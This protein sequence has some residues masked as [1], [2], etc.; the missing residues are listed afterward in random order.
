MESKKKTK[1]TQIFR[2]AYPH[3][4]GIE[5]VMNQINDCLPDADFEK[6]VL[7]CSN[8][9][10]SSVENGVKYNRCK[11]LFEFASNNISPKFIWELSK[12]KTDIIHYHMPF[13]FA[14]IA[15]FIARPKYKKLYIT[16]HSSFKGYEKIMKPFWGL[17]RKFYDSADKIHIL[18]HNIIEYDC[19]LE[20][21]KNKCTVIPYGINT[22]QY[23]NSENVE[24]IRANYSSKKILLCLGRLM[25]IK[26]F[27]YV[28]ESMKNIKNAVLLIAGNGDELENLQKIVKQNN[29][30]QK[31]FFVGELVDEQI[32]A[33]YYNAC[34]IFV[35]P[36]I[37][38]MFGIV[39]LEAMR[40]GK[41]VINTNLGTGANY[42]SLNKETGLTVEPKNV[43]QLT[44]AIN[45]LLNNDELRLRY[46]RNARKRVEDL[47]DIKKIKNQYVEAYK[48]E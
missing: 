11:Y 38:D 24:Q 7:T 2:Y 34:D 44:N 35:F 20:P 41:P 43:E 30:E 6:E 40:C 31:V 3:I 28:I 37:K 5:T 46:G 22:N 13:I 42:V 23:F 18:A 16:Y 8:S 45:E 1:I 12:V 25:K 9:E 48:S 33:E 32:K 36:S 4:G 10:K 21:F 39:Q 29:L 27:N 47:F 15:H 17:L 26:G 14:V 19:F